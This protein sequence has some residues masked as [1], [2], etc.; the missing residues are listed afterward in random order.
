MK[1]KKNVFSHIMWFVYSALVCVG[2]LGMSSALS[3]WAGYTKGEGFTI[4]GLW[5]IVCGWIVFFRK[6]HLE[7][8][9]YK[10]RVSRVQALVIEILFAVLLLVAGI[11]LRVQSIGEAESGAG[12]FELAKVA[13]GQNIPPVVHGA[14][15]IYL[16]LL[17]MV[18]LVFGNIFQAGVWLQIVLLA[19][20]GIFLYLTV[21]KVSGVIASS[22]MLTFVAVGPLM[23]DKS[24]ALSPELLF[25]AI[26]A[27]ALFLSTLCIGGKKHPVSCLLA[28]LLVGLICYLDIMGVTLLLFVLCGIL[29]TRSDESRTFPMRLL[30]GLLALVGSLV[31]FLL[32]IAMDSLISAKDFLD[33][34]MAWGQLYKPSAFVLPEALSI[35]VPTVEKVLLLLLLP[36]GAVSYWFVRD[37]ER[38]SIWIVT[39]ISMILMTCFGMT[40]AEMDG[41]IQIYLIL[42]VLAGTSISS[43]YSFGVEVEFK[44]EMEEEFEEEPENELYIKELDTQE[45]AVE[46]IEVESE[47]I[48]LEELVPETEETPR[49]KVTLLE[50]PLP[51]PKA[52]VK[53]KLEYDIVDIHPTLNCYDVRVPYNDDYDI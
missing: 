1:L 24:L 18:F 34:L 16:N 29:V 44:E 37:K 33:V 10:Q 17:H 22:V 36:I 5:V 52:H 15:Y 4:C 11:F 35:S 2:L 23:I 9:D 8:T 49:P 25:L 46:E 26:Y 6:Q 51:L 42:A 3:N 39:L 20:A 12:Y 38:Q 13:E 48:A 43:I 50:N 31:G 47:P 40:T 45:P 19:V 14:A 41:M 7:N 53:K 32:F 21:R 30:G 27:V 28:G